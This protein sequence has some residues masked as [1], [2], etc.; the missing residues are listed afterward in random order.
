MTDIKIRPF[1][2]TDIPAIRDIFREYE[3]YLNIDLCFQ[4]FEDELSNLPGDYNAPSGAIFIALVDDS[5]AGCV[6]L[7]PMD[8]TTC[9]MKRL[10]VK[11]DFRGL[12]LGRKLAVAIMDKA[13]EIGYCK[14]RLDTLD[15]LK[16]AMKLYSSLGF[17]KIKSYYHNPLK[18]VVYWELKLSD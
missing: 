13:V 10:Y 7:R 1:D 5:L 9:E 15:R 18:G 8:R 14:M 6:A 11:P 3:E 2:I 4:N 12:G 17:R 16:E